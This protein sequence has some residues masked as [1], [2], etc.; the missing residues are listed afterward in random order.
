MGALH[1][2]HLSLIRRSVGENPFTVVSVFVNPTQ[3]GDPSDLGGYPRNLDRDVALATGAGADLI[4]APAVDDVYPSGFATSVEVRGLSER[5]EG[6]ARPDHF[7]GVSTVVTILL[8]LMRPAR[9]Y[10]GEKDYQQLLII[11]RLHHDLGLPGGIVACPTVRD[12]DGLAL[13]SRN[14]RLTPEARRQALALPR[15]LAKM[16][17]LADGGEQSAEEI[18]VAGIDEIS[19]APEVAIEYLAV[20][21]GLTLEPITTLQPGARALV[22]VRVGGIRLID[23][24]PLIGATASRRSESS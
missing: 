3:F 13:S 10:F 15:A 21:D 24:V 8:A 11:H 1:E 22:A 7:R 9:T 20:V 16:R 18:L 23:N 4:F 2:G 14:Q 6:A 19:T 5:W 12:E 17:Q